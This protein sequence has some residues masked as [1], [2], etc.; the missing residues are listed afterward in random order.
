MVSCGVWSIVSPFLVSSRRY[1]L[2]LSLMVSVRS[3]LWVW[4]ISNALSIATLCRFA[5]AGK[6]ECFS[7]ATYRDAPLAS[8]SSLS[9]GKFI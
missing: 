3:L 8:T 5:L 2:P 7:P 6:V 1:S 4:T 9:G